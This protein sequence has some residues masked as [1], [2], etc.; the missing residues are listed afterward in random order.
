MNRSWPGTEGAKGLF[1]QSHFVESGERGA[2]VDGGKAL[3][4]RL[5]TGTSFFLWAVG[6]HEVCVSRKGHDQSCILGG[7]LKDQSR[8]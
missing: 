6:S 7:S 1:R 3:N 2:G 5:K 4:A 8:G